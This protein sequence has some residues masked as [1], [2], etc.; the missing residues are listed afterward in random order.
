[1]RL[2]L[3]A[4]ILVAALALA[5]S[6]CKSRPEVSATR[7]VV[8]EAAAEGARE[9]DTGARSRSPDFGDDEASDAPPSIEEPVPAELE[10]P[11]AELRVDLEGAVRRVFGAPTHCLTPGSIPA[12]AREIEVALE[13][14]LRADGRAAGAAVTAPAVDA[15]ARAC[16]L[17]RARGLEVPPPIPDAPATVRTVIALRA[18]LP[19]SANASPTAAEGPPLAEGARPPGVVLPAQGPG[20]R[21]AGFVAPDV[22]LPAQA[23]HAG[24][25]PGAV[26]PEIT[27]PAQGGAGTVWISGSAEARGEVR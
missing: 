27:L 12:G 24:P 26:P 6:G 17:A 9:P 21:P 20:G 11:E 5:G 19:P 25:A 14:V 3:Q 1:M 10:T 4:P 18:P 15:A 16:L 2:T 23:A 8:P 13:V 22:T 7:G